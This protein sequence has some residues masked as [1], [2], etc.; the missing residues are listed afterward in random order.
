MPLAARRDGVDAGVQL[1]SSAKARVAE[2][3]KFVSIGNDINYLVEGVRSN[4]EQL[5][6]AP[7]ARGLI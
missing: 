4:L 6:W 2:G 1:S 5:G 7:T 3:Y